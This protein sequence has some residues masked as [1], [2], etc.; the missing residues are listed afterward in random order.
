MIHISIDPKGD[1]TG[2]CSIFGLVDA[3]LQGIKDVTHSTKRFLKATSSGA[4]EL[5]KQER[6]Q[7][8]VVSVVEMNG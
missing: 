5:T 4:R 7:K 3:T 2:G 8:G 1:G 6:K